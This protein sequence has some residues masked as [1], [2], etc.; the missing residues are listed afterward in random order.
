MIAEDFF[1]GFAADLD[2]KVGL[3]ILVA[4]NQWRRV[5]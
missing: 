4:L 1:E 2:K 3:F 5:D